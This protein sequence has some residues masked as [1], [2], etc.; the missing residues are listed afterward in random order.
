MIKEMR[1]R[2]ADLVLGWASTSSTLRRL[3]K[4]SWFISFP[5][6]L[7]P[8]ELHFGYRANDPV[9]HQSLLNQSLWSISYLDSDTV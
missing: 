3:L 8:I 5:E 2:G 9:I 7:R 4:S 1:S 6:K